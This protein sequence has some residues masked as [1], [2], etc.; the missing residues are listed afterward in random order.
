MDCPY[1]GEEDACRK[2][3]GKEEGQPHDRCYGQQDAYFFRKC[4]SVPAVFH[5]AHGLTVEP[6]CPQPAIEAV[7]AAREAERGEQ[8]ER[9]G[10]QHGEKYAENA[11][12]ETDESQRHKENFF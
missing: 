10:R 5:E 9:D 6:R 4:H 11:E 2:E 3:I 1:G 12:P 8:D 7:R